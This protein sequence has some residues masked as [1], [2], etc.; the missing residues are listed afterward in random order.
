MAAT[1]ATEVYKLTSRG[2]YD[3]IVVSVCVCVFFYEK[4]STNVFDYYP[5]F[6]N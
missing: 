2:K 3:N 6:V 5:T 4:L 1:A